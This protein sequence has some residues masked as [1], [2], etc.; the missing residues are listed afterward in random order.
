MT[1]SKLIMDIAPT[2]PPTVAATGTLL[3]LPPFSVVLYC[4]SEVE[5]GSTVVLKVEVDESCS[6]SISGGESIMFT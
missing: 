3:L 2:T 6:V 5:L 1:A 4:G